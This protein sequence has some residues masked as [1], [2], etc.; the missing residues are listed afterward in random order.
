MQH[1]YRGFV[2]SGLSHVGVA[3]LI[4][5]HFKIWVNN[6]R[7]W[8]FRCYFRILQ[9]ARVVKCENN[10][11]NSKLCN[12]DRVAGKILI[13]LYVI[14]NAMLMMTR[15]HFHKTSLSFGTVL[16]VTKHQIV[17][18][19]NSTAR[20]NTP[21]YIIL[22]E[23]WI[24]IQKLLEFQHLPEIWYQCWHPGFSNP[25]ATVENLSQP[26]NSYI[27]PIDMPP[28]LQRHNQPSLLN[29]RCLSFWRCIKLKYISMISS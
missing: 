10:T 24:I 9:H 1:F 27:I 16:P 22:L 3:C 7:A 2:K 20:L 15:A 13:L 4:R 8:N 21:A 25:W 18:N 17:R 29:N 28:K 14:S 19:S 6:S 23:M 11:E 5:I 12:S 26:S